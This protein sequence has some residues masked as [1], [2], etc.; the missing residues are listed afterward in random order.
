MAA[1]SDLNE[2]YAQHIKRL[3]PEDRLQLMAVMARDLA[4][5]ARLN[6]PLERSLLE[7]EGLGADIWQGI[8]AQA[9]VQGL[10]EEWDHSP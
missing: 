3:P 1:R 6:I 8:D 2:L 4:V 9:Y 5:D 10:R 7:L